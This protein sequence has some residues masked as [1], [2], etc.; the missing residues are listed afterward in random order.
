VALL[1][2][3][4]LTVA[5]AA[6]PT[7]QTLRDAGIGD[8]LLVENIVLHRDNGVLTLKTGA[9]ALT[10]PVAGRDTLAVF[11]GEGEFTFDPVLPVEKAHLKLMTD[12]ETVREPFDRALFCFSD[13][14]GKEI[15]G[16]TRTPKVD[17]KLADVL[18]EYRKLLRHTP[19]IRRSMLEA[20]LTSDTMDNLEADLLADL[21]NPRQPGFFS[22]YLHGRKH[23]DL[24]FHVKPRGAI[25]DMAPEEVAVINLD[26]G[27]DQEGIWYLAHLKNEIAQGTASSNEDH[28][29][30]A[31]ESYRIETTIAR[32]DH[33]T[34]TTQLKFKAVADG[35]RVIKFGLLPYLRV[36]RVSSGGQ[37]VT[38]IQEPVREDG[39]LYVVMPQPMP[40]GSSYELLIEYVGDKVVRKEG[41]GNFAVGAR[42]SW[43]PAVNS[44]HDHALYSLVFKVPKQYTLAGVGKLVKEWTEKDFACTEWNSEVPV[45]VAGFNYGAFKKAKPIED[46]PTHMVVDGFAATEAPDYLKLAEGS[47]AMGSLTPSHLLDQG[48]AKAQMSLRIF[49]AWFG[50]SEFGKLS[51]TQQPEFNFGQSWPTLVYIPMSAFMDGTQRW[52]LMGIQTRLTEFVDEVIPHEV[53]HQWWG[54]MV[55]WSSYHDQWLSEGFAEF[56]AGLYL[57]FTEKDP[58]KYLKYWDHARELLVQKNSY[59]RRPNDA[60][61]LWMGERLESVRNSGAYNAVV[62]RKGG[63]A[64]HML[65]YL[66]RDAKEGDRYFM[67]T[68]QDFVATYMNRNASTEDFERVVEKH[69]RP[70]MDMGDHT[71]KWFFNEWVCGTAIPKYKFDYTLTPQA[72]G[73][74]LLKAALTQS[75][76]TPDFVMQVPL[77]L[78]FDGQLTRLGSVRVAGNSTNDKIEVTLPK[79]PKRVLINAYRD[80]LEQ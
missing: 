36:T 43:Y 29:V 61:P 60:G 34:A 9:I 27:A 63:Y 41:G 67:E 12:Q 35:D 15:R 3:T 50:K 1:I 75:E 74:V 20:I 77:Y 53:S 76:V 5:V 47:D 2:S 17:P 42:E 13:D 64:L 6:D 14:T 31:A 21:S 56:S 69:M 38:F 8:S 71:M 72:D 4:A 16:Q 66:M 58:G 26:P 32:N 49:N 19:E 25:P 57:Q 59:G 70:S 10:P 30:V 18:R 22:A 62:Y 44:F 46:E 68:M 48:M 65:R 54:H 24:R 45:P 52:Q 73:K 23:S 33:F 80:V 28:R 55:G 37:D 7:Y 40:R 11:V 51:V 79:K 78:D 39:S